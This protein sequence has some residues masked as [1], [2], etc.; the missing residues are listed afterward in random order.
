MAEQQQE[1]EPEI[2]ETQYVINVSG[3]GNCFFYTFYLAHNSLLITDDTVGKRF[4]ENLFLTEEETGSL[5]GQ[6]RIDFN[7]QKDTM[8]REIHKYRGVAFKPILDVL[9]YFARKK[10]QKAENSDDVN[11]FNNYVILVKPHID[12]FSSQQQDD[13]TRE[14]I[15]TLTCS[16][17]FALQRKANDLYWLFLDKYIWVEESNVYELEKHYNMKI[18]IKL[19]IEQT[20]EFGFTFHNPPP[21]VTF[22]PD[23][24][25]DIIP[26]LIVMTNNLVHYDLIVT[27]R[28]DK[29]CSIYSVNPRRGECGMYSNYKTLLINAL[30][31]YMEVLGLDE[32]QNPDV[33]KFINHLTGGQT[34]GEV[35]YGEIG[36]ETPPGTEESVSAYSETSEFKDQNTFTTLIDMKSFMESLHDKPISGTTDK[37]TICADVR[38]MALLK[39]TR[40]TQGL[41]GG[42]RKSHTK[43]NRKIVLR[44]R[45]S[46]SLRH[47]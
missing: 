29:Y 31:K 30:Y 1:Q 21:I 38:L 7:D 27:K 25:S 14:F 33:D 4:G 8:A 24:E 15:E 2:H 17:S 23:I 9:V 18:L 22:I 35:Y 19:I 5:K 13:R 34:P 40:A 37:S 12:K 6:P 42:G 16:D 10:Q 26:T 3:D 45:K 36:T 32:T 28:G 39:E 44:P 41:L 46:N 43:K 47:K 11:N 20:G